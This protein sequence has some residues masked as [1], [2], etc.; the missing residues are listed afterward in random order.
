MAEWH[1][2]PV[3]IAGNWTDEMLH[4]MVE[5]LADRKQRTSDALA[6]K[7]SSRAGPVSNDVTVSDTALFAQLGSKLKVTKAGG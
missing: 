6:G 1:L 2:D 4:I 5:K 3:Y 7:S